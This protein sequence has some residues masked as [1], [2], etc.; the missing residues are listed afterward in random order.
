MISRATAITAGVVAGVATGVATTAV[1]LGTDTVTDTL[2]RELIVPFGV[3]IAGG[4]LY[5][6]GSVYGGAGSRGAQLLC[7]NVG[8]GVGIGAAAAF[9]GSFMLLPFIA[10]DRKPH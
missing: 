7:E 9:F 1:V 3:G 5:A 10:A 4:G 2:A 8:M 6:L